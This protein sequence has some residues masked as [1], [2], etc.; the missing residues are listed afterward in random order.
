M[1]NDDGQKQA[2]KTTL[3]GFVLAG[4][5]STRM[6]RDKALLELGGEPLLVR[7]A[8]LVGTVVGK[9]AVVIGPAELYWNLKLAVV[10]DDW[11]GAGPLGGIATALRVSQAEWNLMVACDL[12]YL[13]QPWLEF[14]VARARQGRADAVLPI[15]FSGA[16]PLCAMY[17]KNCESALRSALENGIRKVTDGLARVRLERIEPEEW[18]EFDAD[19]SLFKN[20]NSP[21]DYEEAKRRWA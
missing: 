1:R 15:N 13:T 9:Q 8:R 18:R 4:G 12:P 11:P 19:G 14:L 16:E 20:M 7:T 10:Q 5:E 6:G 21:A 3:G 2:T 17:H